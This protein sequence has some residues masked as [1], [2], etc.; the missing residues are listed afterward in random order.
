LISPASYHEKTGNSDLFIKNISIILKKNEKYDSLSPSS[1]SCL[2]SPPLIIFSKNAE[3]LSNF[4]EKKG[5]LWLR[6]T[7]IYR[8]FMVI[9]H[10]VIVL[11]LGGIIDLK[12][13]ITASK[14]NLVVDGQNP[15]LLTE[16]LP[17]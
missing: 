4:C 14:I 5:N 15:Q 12:T 17:K 13:V 6:L 10:L 8:Q 3:I 16:I 1:I 2:K 9:R 7:G 11:K